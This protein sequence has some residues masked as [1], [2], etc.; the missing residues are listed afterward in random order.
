[1]KNIQKFRALLR[2]LVQ[3]SIFLQTPAEIILDFIRFFLELGTPGT[4]KI[5]ELRVYTVNFLNIFQKIFQN[6][7]LILNF[8]RSNLV[9]FFRPSTLKTEI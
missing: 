4:N 5:K 8:L 1:M 6:K 3:K 2:H 9:A 7:D